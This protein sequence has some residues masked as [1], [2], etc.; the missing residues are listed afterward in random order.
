MY[1][2]KKFTAYLLTYHNAASYYEAKMKAKYMWRSITLTGWEG[3]LNVMFHSY[4]RFTKRELLR[5]L[6]AK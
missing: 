1:F 5:E 3:I 2:T 4:L 6:F